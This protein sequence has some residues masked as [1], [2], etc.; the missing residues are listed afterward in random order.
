[1]YQPAATVGIVGLKPTFGLI[2][3]TGIIASE[4]SVDHTGPMTR[5]VM[6]NAQLLQAVAG[7]DGLDDRQIAGTPFRDQVPDYPSLLAAA[8]SARALLAVAA[9]G[10]SAAPGETRKLRIGILKEGEMPKMMDPRVVALCREAAKKFEQLGA[11]VVEVSV[12]GH[13]TAPLIGRAYR[14][15]QSN[16]F[17]GRMSGTRQLYHNDLTEKILPWTQEKFDKVMP[18]SCTV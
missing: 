14:M 12:P 13:S 7:V 4:T 9:K 17:L 1:M 15:T 5:D 8:K 10:T 2:P 6:S 18:T 3:Y 16:I 11:E